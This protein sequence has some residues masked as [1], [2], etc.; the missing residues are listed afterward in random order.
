MKLRSVF[1]AI[2]VSMSL[3]GCSNNEN[4]NMEGDANNTN[5]NLDGNRAAPDSIRKQSGE[6]TNGNNTTDKVSGDNSY[7]QPDNSAGQEK[8]DK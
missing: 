7:E 5:A 2:V 1:L 6:T 3:S 4:K 8:K